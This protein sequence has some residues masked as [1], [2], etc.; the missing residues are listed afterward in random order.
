MDQQKRIEQSDLSKHDIFDGLDNASFD[1][2][3]LRMAS[4]EL[5]PEAVE[6]YK[7]DSDTGPKLQERYR[8]LKQRF[9]EEKNTYFE[10]NSFATTLPKS[11]EAIQYLTEV[12]ERKLSGESE[13]HQTGIKIKTAL[14]NLK[15]YE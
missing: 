3:T 6:K 4:G 9:D 1:E 8:K 10:S 15:R 2:I 11:L 12:I 14:K 5:S 13:F 7:L